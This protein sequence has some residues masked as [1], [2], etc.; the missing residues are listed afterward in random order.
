MKGIAP[1]NS[2]ASLN[3]ATERLAAD[4]V[5][6][7]MIWQQTIVRTGHSRGHA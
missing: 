3:K 1:A 4:G 7:R 2:E 5:F 6:V